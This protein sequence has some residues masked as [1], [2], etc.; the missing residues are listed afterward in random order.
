MN[1]GGKDFD[2]GEGSIYFTG[3][4]VEVKFSAKDALQVYRAYVE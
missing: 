1:A 4:G 3:Q 2:L